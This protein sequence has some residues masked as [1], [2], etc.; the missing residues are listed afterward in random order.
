MMLQLQI[1]FDLANVCQLY[2][3]AK[4]FYFISFLRT[5]KI[6]HAVVVTVVLSSAWVIPFDA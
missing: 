1:R 5:V 4:G 3:P 6:F 2:P